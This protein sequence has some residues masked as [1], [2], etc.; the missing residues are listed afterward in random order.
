MI[1]DFNKVFPKGQIFTASELKNGFC[2]VDGLRPK[3]NGTPWTGVVSLGHIVVLGVAKFE[4][5]PGEG[6]D[7]TTDKDDAPQAV[8]GVA[9]EATEQA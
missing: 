4:I 2:D 1:A 6:D 9:V 3:R 8:Q 7:T 5:V